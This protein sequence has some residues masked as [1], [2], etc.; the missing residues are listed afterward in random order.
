[1]QKTLIFQEADYLG[2]APAISSLIL[3]DLCVDKAFSLLSKD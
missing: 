3:Q 2:I 1:M